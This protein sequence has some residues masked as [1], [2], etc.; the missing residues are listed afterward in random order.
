MDNEVKKI[1]KKESVIGLLIVISVV[2]VISLGVWALCRQLYNLAPAA[3]ENREVRACP[4]IAKWERPTLEEYKKAN[5]VIDVLE[6]NKCVMKTN[7][8]QNYFFLVSFVYIAA[9]LWGLFAIIMV[10]ASCAEIVNTMI[11][12]NENVKN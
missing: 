4:K 8:R 3:K 6:D 2:L 12:G 9:G 10:I 1:S 5:G 7:P 11:G